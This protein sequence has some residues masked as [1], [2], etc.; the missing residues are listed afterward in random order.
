MKTLLGGALIVTPRGFFPPKICEVCG[1]TFTF[2]P[3][4]RRLVVRFCKR[5]CHGETFCMAPLDGDGFCTTCGVWQPA[6]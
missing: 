2:D 3:V 6:P 5:C 4:D 1:K